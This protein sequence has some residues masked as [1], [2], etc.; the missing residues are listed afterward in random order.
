MAQ[1]T[2][3]TEPQTPEVVHPPLT[4]QQE[5]AAQ[6]LAYGGYRKGVRSRSGAVSLAASMAKVSRQTIHAWLQ[7]PNFVEE[8]EKQRSKGIFTAWKGLMLGADGGNATSCTEILNRLLKSEDP[9]I[10]A[11]KLRQAHEREMKEL[12]HQHRLIEIEKKAALGL[13]VND[14]PITYNVVVTEAPMPDKPEGLH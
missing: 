4:M 10:V 5:V 12:E 7:N 1:D 2:D 13:P 6:A 3:S 11:L 8:I 9:R 14:E